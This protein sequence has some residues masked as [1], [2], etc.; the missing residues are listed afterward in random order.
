MYEFKKS[1]YLYKDRCTYDSVDKQP[2][3]QKEI[4]E[5]QYRAPKVAPVLTLV[6][7]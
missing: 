6:V 5:D 3:I 4:Q 7:C 2:Y 1:V